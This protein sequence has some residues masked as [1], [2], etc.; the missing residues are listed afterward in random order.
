MAM[1]KWKTMESAPWDGTAVLAFWPPTRG[2]KVTER[3]YG[4]TKYRNGG[5]VNVDDCGESYSEP[6]HWMPLP[7]PPK[8]NNHAEGADK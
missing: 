5:W 3:S 7:A 4:V 2:S 6:T 8:E 1:G